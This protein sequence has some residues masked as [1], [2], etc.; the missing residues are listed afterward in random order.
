MSDGN[1]PVAETVVLG[2][3]EVATVPPAAGPRR[4]G[5]EALGI[6]PRG[7]IAVADGRILWVGPEAELAGAVR[8]TPE[9]IELRAD[10]C[11]V[12][13]GLVECHTHLVYGGERSAEFEQRCQGASY[14]EIAA[15]GGGILATVGATRLASEE[16]L[17]RGAWARLQRL[18]AQGVTTCEIKSGYGLTLADELKILRVVRTL[19]GLQP[20]RLVP[21][22]LAAHAV[23]PEYR[24]RR[25]GY[26]RLVCE[27]GIPAGAE[28]GLAPG[29]DVFCEQGAF[30]V[31]EARQV[32]LA[33]RERGLTLH[34]HAEQFSAS[35]GARL[36]VELGASSADHLEAVTE[37]DAWL[38]AAADVVAVALPACNVFLDQ[39]ER[40]PA[41]R[42]LE[43]GVRVAL[44]TD[45]NPGTSPCLS[46]WLVATLGC[47]LLH[48]TAAE[49]LAGLTAEPAR[50]L[51]LQGQ[52]GTLQPGAAADLAAFPVASYRQLPYAFGALAA[53]WVM[54][55]GRQ[56]HAAG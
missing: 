31:A 14:L 36:A 23:P 54:V 46:P 33:A 27:E 3:T 21:T 39:P 34:L 20:V 29:C 38:L 24:E 28:E 17:T 55:G 4:P 26:V 12:T 47:S 22:L 16:E 5:P 50:A 19:A 35:G 41:R 10:G 48:L 18:L 2:A 44:S 6:V 40:M 51:G 30:S 53:R 49:S 13:P 37:S 32:L 11:L 56:V 7:A 25:A 52:R 42:L 45:H 43:A 1:L 9:T 15:A 8:R